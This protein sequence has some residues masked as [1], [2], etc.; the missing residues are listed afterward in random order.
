MTK[1][2]PVLPYGNQRTSVTDLTHNK[3]LA[4]IEDDT[5]LIKKLFTGDNRHEAAKQWIRENT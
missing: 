5:R 3:A 4:I 2:E 1:F